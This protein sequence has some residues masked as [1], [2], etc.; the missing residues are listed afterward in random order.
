MMTI[1]LNGKNKPTFRLGRH[2]GNRITCGM[3]AGQPHCVPRRSV[4]VRPSVRSLSLGRDSSMTVIGVI[5]TTQ[6]PF[7]SSPSSFPPSLPLPLCVTDIQTELEV[8]FDGARR[9][10]KSIMQGKRG[11]GGEGKH[12]RRSTC[13]LILISMRAYHHHHHRPN[14]LCLAG[15]ISPW[16]CSASPP[17]LLMTKCMKNICSKMSSFHNDCFW[18][19]SGTFVV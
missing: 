11:R 7:S 15:Y 8:A 12:G 4:H 2:R 6:Q 16:E 19:A 9:R 18:I 1:F 17:P 10:T 13:S 3:E 5:K 14:A